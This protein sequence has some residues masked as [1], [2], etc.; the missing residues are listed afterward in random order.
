MATE[1]ATRTLST[2]NIVSNKKRVGYRSDAFFIDPLK[3]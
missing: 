1:E 2:V 3:R